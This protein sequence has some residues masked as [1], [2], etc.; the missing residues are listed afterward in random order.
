MLF[1]FFA[2]LHL[3]IWYYRYAFRNDLLLYLW[4]SLM[5]LAPWISYMKSYAWISYMKSYQ[6]SN[7]PK[8]KSQIVLFVNRTICFCAWLKGRC[9]SWRRT[10]L[11]A[12]TE[13]STSILS[14]ALIWWLTS[15]L[16]WPFVSLTKAVY[17]SWS[18]ICI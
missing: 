5:L 8:V 14:L 15:I 10:T 1:I 18:N 17:I 12:I 7:F 13:K 2:F 6:E 11:A 3:L 9:E 16:S 4:W